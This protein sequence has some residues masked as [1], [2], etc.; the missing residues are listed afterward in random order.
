MTDVATPRPDSQRA[1]TTLMPFLQRVAP[2]LLLV[3]L[4]P[5]VAEFLLGDF[6]ARSIGLI[7]VFMPLYGC[8]ALLVRELARRTGRGWPTMLFLA[9]AY[10]LIEEGYTT[11]SL[12]NPSY[13]GQRLLDYGYIPFLG[14]S[15]HWALFVLAI[16]VVWSISTPILIAEGIAGDRRTTPWLRRPGL[17]VTAVLYVLGCATTTA[18][19]F[20]HSHFVASVP[21]FL[22][23]AVLVVGAVIVALAAFSPGARR[24]SAASAGRAPAP[25]VVG[26]VAFVL[27][28]AFQL[29]VFDL[30]SHDVPAALTVLA[31]V[32]LELAAAL[33]L[34]RWSRGAGW[35]PAHLLALAAAAVLTY[36]WVGMNQFL[37]GRTNLGAC[38]TP[39]EVGAQVVEILAVLGLVAWAV[40][41]DRRAA[42]REPAAAATA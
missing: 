20:Q 14:T 19:T 26:V 18:F 9:L 36:A 3:V 25:W 28:S 31:I 6:S 17:A 13:A 32:A 40:L 12:F 29:V 35:T 2:A 21:E 1:A 16:H 41:R 4:A 24:G 34:A 30:P 42:V 10:A 22:A 23:V 39:V 27:A 11:Q 8:G 5:L 38:V 15:L 7:V 33:L 37:H